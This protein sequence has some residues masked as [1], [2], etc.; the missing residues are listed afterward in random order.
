MAC[1][2]RESFAIDF[3]RSYLHHGIEKDPARLMARVDGVTAEDIQAVAQEIFDKEKMTT[4]M[5]V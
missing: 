5:I 3:G 1:D 2:N 4:L